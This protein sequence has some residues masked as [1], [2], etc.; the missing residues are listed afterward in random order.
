V[1]PTPL[2]REARASSWRVLALVLLSASYFYQSSGHNEA[3][4]FDQIRSV[5]E[6]GEWWID[7]F[8]R[9]TGD[10]IQANE[11]IYPN[12]AP[13]TTLLGLIPWKLLR[14]S[15]GVLPLPEV[16]QLVL[17]TWGLTVLLSAL[18][19][20]LISIL[21]LRFLARAGWSVPEATLASLG[22]GL[23][24]IAFPWATVFFS[25]QLAAFFAFAAFYLVW[26]EPW[27]TG[28]SR[29]R[30]VR[31]TLAGLLLGFLPV[32][33]Y[34]GAIASGLIGLYALL[35]VGPRAI[36]PVVCGAVIGLMPLPL[37]NQM[38]LGSASV[39]SYS[40]YKD[41][42]AFP[43]HQRGIAGV[44]WPRLEV[45]G[46]ITFRAQRGLF[47]ANPW[48]A[49]LVATPFL[50]P[51]L[52]V[53]ARELAL[54]GAILLGFLLF[55]A[56]FGDSIIYWGGA[57]S[58][59]PRHILIAVPFA[60]LLAAVPLRVRALAPV[61]AVL[62]VPTMLLML[63]ASAI[64]PRLPYEPR[65]PFSDFYLPL[66]ARGLLSTYPW[67]TFGETTLFGS[68]GAF[69]LGRALGLP[70][71][72]EVLPLCLAWAAGAIVLFRAASRGAR[73]AA[74]MA[75]A[76]VLAVGFWP[77]R[78][79]L[80]GQGPLEPGLCQAISA[81]E[82][83]P[84]FSDYDLQPEPSRTAVRLKA[85]MPS[86]PLTRESDAAA[87]LAKIA[88]TFS[89][90]YEPEASGWHLFR[91]RAIGEAALYIDGLHRLKIEGP[92]AFERAGDVHLYLSKKPHDIVVRYMSDQ[93]VRQLDVS[94][95]WNDR[96]ASPLVA[97]LQSRACR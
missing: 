29:G 34:P 76:A 10:V 44:S 90:R 64:D 5:A 80:G 43:A 79:R 93:A 77:A 70:R 62:I 2:T 20:S 30:L 51:R 78:L 72:L 89:G 84:Y 36:G 7:R 74:I 11:H 13:G 35:K 94:V 83:W 18:P 96:P 28:R 12:K 42:S 8:A 59:G 57:F 40:F 47:H 45:L 37:Y 19:T 92:A 81:G 21:I 4:R 14:A 31:L 52:R 9:N 23:G 17:V 48:L 55:N 53:P 60:V 22:Y 16:E 65:E 1:E 69:N 97:G 27:A 26:R 87:S 91:V 75:A 88:V 67:P 38:A 39:L 49:F 6:H 33:E 24:T 82:V 61:M 58:F 71:D 46:E 15:A 3:A 95:G 85:A 54:A 68:T 73:A 86:I 32:I 66:Y 41:G 63:V 56:G 25:H 50:V